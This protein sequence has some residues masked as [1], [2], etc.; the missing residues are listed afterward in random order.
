M[1]SCKDALPRARQSMRLDLPIC[2]AETMQRISDVLKS[3]AANLGDL[4]ER[5]KHE[6]QILMLVD[7]I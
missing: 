6:P 5:N 7:P 4:A 1:P 2:D 3:L